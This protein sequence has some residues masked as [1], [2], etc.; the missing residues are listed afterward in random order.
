M[1]ECKFL[2]DGRKVV[3]VGQLNQTEYIVQEIFVTPQG[4]ELPSGERFTTKS[5]HSTPV[6][7][8]KA[9]E[10]DRLNSRIDKLKLDVELKE[11]ELKAINLKK[12][13]NAEILKQ[14]EMHIKQV[15]SGHSFDLFCDVIAGN[16]LWGVKLDYCDVIHENNIGEIG[17]SKVLADMSWR[18]ESFDSV[19]LLGLFGNAAGDLTYK[20]NSYKDG[21]GGWSTITFIRS[22]KELKELCL[23]KLTQAVEKESFAYFTEAVHFAEKIGCIVPQEVKDRFIE[24]NLKGIESTYKASIDAANQ[25]KEESMKKHSQI[26]PK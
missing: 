16:V 7:S 17:S 5:L 9:Q 22:E 14:S 26:L 12:Q 24:Y 20:L 11:K 23:S 18:A 13:A 21:S 25:R 6:K 2:S 4:D 8:Y 15:L 19:R 1:S 10:E 3:I